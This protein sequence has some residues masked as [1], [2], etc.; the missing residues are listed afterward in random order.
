MVDVSI[1]ISL[2]NLLLALGRE[3]GVTIVLISMTSRSRGTFAR[4]G[5]IGVMFLGRVVELGDTESLAV[6]RRIRIP[7]RSSRR[8]L[9]PTRHH[10][11][12][13]ACR[14]AQR[15]DPE[16]ASAS[17]RMHLHPRCRCSRRVSAT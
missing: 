1:R 6:T 15:R 14:A 7:R 16:P 12:Q 13:E 11:L 4:D 2:L 9:R 5:R 3:F 17:A 10:P 8:S